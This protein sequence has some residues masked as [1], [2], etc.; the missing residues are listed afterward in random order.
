LTKPGIGR[1][2]QLLTTAKEEGASDLHLMVGA[3]PMMRLH[4][5]LNPLAED[6]LS[7][8]DILDVHY[9]K[10][11]APQREAFENRGEYDLAF[12]S[13]VGRFR[14]HVYRQMG[15][16]AIVFRVGKDIQTADDLG[17]PAEV[18]AL[19]EKRR[20]LVLVTGPAGCGKSTTIALWIDAINREREAHIIT[21]EDPIEYIHFPQKSL[22][23]QRERGLDFG[24]YEEAVEA[25]F[26]QDPDVIMIGNLNNA[27][28]IRSALLAAEAGY[29][30]FGGMNTTS[31]KETLLRMTDAFGETR[32]HY[33]RNLLANVLEA[34]VAQ[35]LIPS[36]DFTSS[37]ASFEVLHADDKVRKMIRGN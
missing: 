2:Q 19:H 28:A 31:G 17:M 22:I 25:A 21:L 8:A 1:I 33:A 14:A 29:L 10:M 37:R 36:K 6:V 24:D 4:S 7:T 15:T 5:K 13:S 35:R 34:I 11:T 23:S 12:A 3:P 32:Q 9:E 20:G 30:V 27:T 16:I 18:F 26:H